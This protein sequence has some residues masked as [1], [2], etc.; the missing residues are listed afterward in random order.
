LRARLPES[1]GTAPFLYSRLARLANNPAAL[2]FPLIGDNAK[3]LDG[4][5]LPDKLV[6]PS[7]LAFALR[8]PARF[9]WLTTQRFLFLWDIKRE[10]WTAYGPLLYRP[11]RHPPQL[12]LLNA[13]LFALYAAGAVLLGSRRPRP[14][15]LFALALVPAALL[16]PLFT[17]GSSRYLIPALPCAALLQGYAVV[18][19]AR[20]AAAWLKRS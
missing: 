9:A 2:G 3:D 8:R 20:I 10:P 19:A 7:G 17:F 11:W 4:A 15:R 13:C 14:E 16:V 6:E 1:R 18:E 5:A 12:A